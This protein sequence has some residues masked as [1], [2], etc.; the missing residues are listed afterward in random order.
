MEL[1][2]NDIIDLKI[3]AITNEGMGLGRYNAENDSTN[4]GFVVFVPLTAPGDL[5]KARILKVTS[6]YAYGKIENIIT[7][8]ND[9]VKIDCEAFTKCGGCDF[10][11][12]NYEAE[13][14]AKSTFIKD[15]FT[16]ISG[17]NPEFLPFIPN[18]DNIRYRNKAQYPVGKNRN[19]EIIYG[20]YRSSSHE[21]I[22]CSDCMLQPVVFKE[23]ADSI[24]DY[25]VKYN[26][27]VYDENEHQGVLRHICIRKGHYTGEV[28]V[29]L[30]AR[31]KVPEFRKLAKHLRAGFPKIMGVILN[32]NKDKTNVIFG[33]EES[34]LDG[35]Q[36]IFDKMCG[37]DVRVSSTS[38]YQVNT[39]TA[40]KLYAA[41]KEFT[42]PKDKTILDLY[43]GVGTIGLSMADEAKEIVGVEIVREAVR[44]AAFN[45]TVNSIKN[46][47]FMCGDVDETVV[48]LL[49]DGF[50]PDT[51]VLDPSRKGC[52]GDTIK[53]IAA[54]QPERVVMVSCNPS[55]AARDCTE[56]GKYGY[57][58]EKVQ[59]VD[60]FSGTVHVECVIGL[61][62][63]EK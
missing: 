52:E 61:R 44:N 40:E 49:N 35:V 14:Y 16:R 3:T 41:V 24:I 32:I 29:T 57:K 6:S 36:H 11:H 27:S 45:A 8:S 10:R 9:R 23:I 34:V 51:V 7:S 60:M 37:L 33:E 26:I 25:A 17:L 15:A 28:L 56:F 63:V 55:T 54:L 39:P 22:P 2:K 21:I 1:Q 48:K 42:E 59:G 5:I 50:K 18:V 47:K 53:N 43:C 13:I 31:R 30:V 38:F 4:E 62:R 58:A 46:A 19:G 12:I 20:F